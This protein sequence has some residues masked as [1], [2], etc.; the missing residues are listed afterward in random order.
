MSDGVVKLIY[1]VYKVKQ[2]DS[3]VCYGY[4]Y[5]ATGCNLSLIVFT[6]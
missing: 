2:R 4:Y 1:V 5:N 6:T 3:A